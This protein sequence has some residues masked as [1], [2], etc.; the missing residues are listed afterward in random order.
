MANY[1]YFCKACD[2]E[3]EA[4]YSMEQRNAPLDKPCPKCKEEKTVRKMVGGLNI[5][6]VMRMGIKRPDAGFQ[7]KLKAIAEKH[8]SGNLTGHHGHNIT[9]F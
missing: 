3:F 6:D 8:N 2:H 4:S 7:A 1:S 9:E 5:G